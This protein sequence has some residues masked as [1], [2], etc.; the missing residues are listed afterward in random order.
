MWQGSDGGGGPIEMN[1][2]VLY[3]CPSH[4]VCVHVRVYAVEGVRVV[5]HEEE[6]ETMQ[7][8]RVAHE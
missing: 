6:F 2:Y 8:C 4:D 1:K 7:R 3:L 5:E